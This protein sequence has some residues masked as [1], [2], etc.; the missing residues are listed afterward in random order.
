LSDNIHPKSDLKV[1]PPVLEIAGRN[2][3]N[4]GIDF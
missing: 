1:A 2:N 4:Y 3:V